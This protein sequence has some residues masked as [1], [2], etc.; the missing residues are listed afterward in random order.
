MELPTATS[1]LRPTRRLA[2]AEGPAPT[3]LPLPLSSN[4]RIGVR[5]KPSTTSEHG[6][7]KGMKR[8][9]GVGGR[10]GCPCSPI[11]VMADRRNERGRFRFLKPID[12]SVDPTDAPTP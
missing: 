8:S 1:A 3:Y 4:R 9:F 10:T 12:E 7:L 11:Q 5:K 2:R 6:P